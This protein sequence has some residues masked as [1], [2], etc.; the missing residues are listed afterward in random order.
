MFMFTANAQPDSMG[1]VYIVTINPDGSS[2]WSYEQR[3][4]F[5]TSYER[6]TWLAYVNNVSTDLPG[7]DDFKQNIAY[8]VQK[9]VENNGR[10]MILGNFTWTT[11]MEETFDSSIGVVSFNFNWKGFAEIQD[12]NIYVGDSFVGFHLPY[13]TIMIFRYPEGWKV[14][15]I[16]PNANYKTGYEIGWYGY[17]DFSSGNPSFELFIPPIWIMVLF[18]LIG[19]GFVPVLLLFFLF[20]VKPINDNQLQLLEMLRQNENRMFQRDLVIKTG[21][22]KSKTSVTLSKMVNNKLVT[23]EKKG[24][25]NL[26]K[27]NK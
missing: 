16:E 21:W 19:L 25:M 24:R 14:S 11:R 6:E 1:E 3:F 18:I 8:I 4:V 12:E 27:L 9:A 13:G 2:S 26:I 5:Q 22:S 7:F 10:P 15:N 20:K 23:K 17:R